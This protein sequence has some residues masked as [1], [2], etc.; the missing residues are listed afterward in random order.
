M[1]C[2]SCEIDCQILLEVSGDPNFCNITSIVIH[3]IFDFNFS[4][5][6][7]QNDFLCNELVLI[8]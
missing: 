4:L 8:L 1:L 5:Q 2:K 3:K 7:E 6:K